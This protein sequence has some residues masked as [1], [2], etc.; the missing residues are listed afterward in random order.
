MSSPASCDF[1][2]IE[3]EKLR[4]LITTLGKEAGHTG[5]A[6]DQWMKAQQ[7]AARLQEKEERENQRKA[8]E[9]ERKERE[10]EKQREEERKYELALRGEEI[11]RQA[12]N[13]QTMSWTPDAPDRCSMPHNQSSVLDSEATASDVTDIISIPKPGPD[14][15]PELEVS[16]ASCQ[17]LTI[18]PPTSSTLEEVS[19]PANP[20]LVF[21]G[22]STEDSFT[23][24]LQITAR[25]DSSP[26]PEHTAS[27]GLA[28]HKRQEPLSPITKGPLRGIAP[29][30]PITGPVDL[31]S[32]P[33]YNAMIRTLPEANLDLLKS[34]IREKLEISPKECIIY[35]GTQD[36]LHEDVALER[37]LDNLG[38]I[39]AEL[40]E[41]NNDVVVKAS[42]W[43]AT[44][45]DCD[46][47]SV[48]YTI[49]KPE[50]GE[51]KQDL[52][53]T[54]YIGQTSRLP[55]TVKYLSG[56]RVSWI[57]LRD[58]QVL[59]TGR[60]TFSTDLR[61]SVLPGAGLKLRGARDLTIQEQLHS[62]VPERKT[63]SFEN[64]TFNSRQATVSFP[65]ANNSKNNE[66]AGRKYFPLFESELKKGNQKLHMNEK[67]DIRKRDISLDV[68]KTPR[69]HDWLKEQQRLEYLTFPPGYDSFSSAGNKTRPRRSLFFHGYQ[70]Y[71]QI[72]SLAT[73]EGRTASHTLKKD[74]NRIAIYPQGRITESR[75]QKLAPSHINGIWGPEDYALQIK[76]TN[77]Q[78]AGT[79]VCQ[80]NTE[81]KIAQAVVLRVV[82]MK[83]EILG[84]RELFVKAG[85]PVNISC[86]VNQGAASP[87]FILWYKGRR[88]VEY[89]NSGGRIKVLTQDGGISHLIL[90][91]VQPD[92]SANYTCSPA[93][94]EPASLILSVIVDER[95]A[96][97][98]QGN[99][100]PSARFHLSMDLLC[101]ALLL[102]HLLSSPTEY[103][104]SV[105]RYLLL[106][107]AGG[108][109]RLILLWLIMK[110]A[111][112]LML[113]CRRFARTNQRACRE[114]LL[115][116]S[117][118]RRITQLL[119][120]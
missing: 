96:A 42:C 68:G 52:N 23:S 14:P 75:T 111:F 32:L 30:V 60:H 98:H 33:V 115:S 94:G 79:Y 19:P 86:Q 16:A 90:N 48:S 36:L 82:Q 35:C 18:S 44:S 1:F 103:F 41:K 100:S 97:M 13:P 59:S 3:L 43:A 110:A 81:P 11:T 47:L 54:A 117:V 85:N 7:D 95:Q 53:V 106:T 15:V 4:T 27:L 114:D 69:N 84:R 80:I 5:P 58:L 57:R 50:F 71:N 8:R 99:H 93:G 73:L 6:L 108:V 61:I 89:E 10:V 24:P 65:P 83:A 39:V 26:V 2:A 102:G 105:S 67:K 113:H 70:G 118:K 38:T 49:P 12:S 78:D 37:V 62:Q 28:F 63:N 91:N 109:S 119:H 51:E 40:K 116:T 87:G 107:M 17:P 76:N 64:P 25:E 66:G 77:P 9:A 20:E 34:W 55:C 29:P 101:S 120:L 46:D 21:E 45:K 88:L 92:D 112:G 104:E 72:E 22:D 31:N 56:K 74:S